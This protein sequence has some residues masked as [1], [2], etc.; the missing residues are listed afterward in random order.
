M[1]TCINC[2]K[3]LAKNAKFCFNCK[4]VQPK[5]I[6]IGKVLVPVLVV[7]IFLI[8]IYTILNTYEKPNLIINASQYSYITKDELVKKLGEPNKIIDEYYIY[9]EMEFTV[10]KDIVTEFKYLP[11]NAVKY[12]FENDIFSMFGIRPN[13]DTITKTFDNNLTYKFQDVT[14]NI[15]QFEIF[16]VNE[17]NKTFG[18]VIIRYKDKIETE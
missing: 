1:K 18:T 5:N 16:D 9:D 7:L 6:N 8:F 10:K 13:K 3:L 15:W 11:N 12:K 14:D 17:K 2:G 4:T